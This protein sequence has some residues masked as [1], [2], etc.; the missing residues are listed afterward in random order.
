MLLTTLLA[1]IFGLY[2]L[3]AG[4]A[5][6]MNRKH[7]VLAVIA[8]AKERSSQLIGG[9]V[10]LLLGLF[11]VNIH[12]DWS[13]LPASLVSLVGWASV[14]KGLAYLFL[15]EATL[16]KYMHLLAERKWYLIDGLAAVLIGLYLAGFGFG[17]F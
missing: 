17:W 15:P 7:M 2:M 5:I 11:I 13:V 3:I 10:A 8:I 14:I 1:K 16:T 12:N 6:L 4:L 9:L